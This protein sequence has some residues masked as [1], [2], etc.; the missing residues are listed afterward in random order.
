VQGGADAITPAAAWHNRR[1][2][3]VNQVWDLNIYRAFTRGGGTPLKFI[4]STSRDQGA[5]YSPDGRI[6]FISDRSGSREIWIA[7][8]DGSG[9][10]RVTNFNS[11]HI[12]HLQWSADGR[13]LAFD[14]RPYGHAEIFIMECDPA[15]LHCAEPKRLMPNTPAEAPGWSADGKFIYFVS[16]RAGQWELWKQPVSGGS[17]VQIARNGAYMSRESVDGKWLYYTRDTGDKIW[18][19]SSLPAAGDSA[20]EVVI[21]SPYRVQTEGWTLTQNEIVFIDR[22]T[23]TRRAA[24]RAYNLATKR[25]RLIMT[26]PEIFPDRSDIGVSISPDSCCVLYSQLD[27]SGSNVMVAQK[28]R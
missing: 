1:V 11:P 22:P 20:E 4:A 21:G 8:S 10:V 26:L 18:R 14:G 19:R 7:R 13:W 2:A 3:W 15:V 16:R 17:S 25:V 6:A 28:M 23:Q 9:Q 5:V 12:D 24:I 27:R